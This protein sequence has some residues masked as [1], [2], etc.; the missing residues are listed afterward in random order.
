MY[1]IINFKE[2]IQVR[3]GRTSVL[4]EVK[5]ASPSKG[6]IAL[7]IDAA[8]Q[9]K[10]MLGD[11]DKTGWFYA[12]AGAATISCLTEPKWFKGC[13][14]DMRSIRE[15]ISSLPYR[16]ALLRKDFIVDEYQIYEARGV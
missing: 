4:A 2:R 12:Q 11:T 9:G 16:P 1:P 10:Y 8:K 3:N 15:A 7:D 14:E 13:L 6:D 5:R